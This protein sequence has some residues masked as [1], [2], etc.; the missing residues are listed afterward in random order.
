MNVRTENVVTFASASKSFNLAGLQNSFIV[1]PDAALREQFD[2][3]MN[4][5]VAIHGG[6]VVGDLA[7]EAAFTGGKPWLNSVRKLVRENFTQIRSILQKKVPKAVVTELEGTY[8]MWIDLRSYVSDAAS[9]KALVQD[10][11]RLAV[12][13]GDWFGG[14]DFVGFIRLN[15]ATGTENCVNAANKLADALAELK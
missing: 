1:I 14:D 9:V 6:C 12:D 11:C 10:R 7:T 15:L 4:A 2:Q 3:Y 13:F 5:H 8:L